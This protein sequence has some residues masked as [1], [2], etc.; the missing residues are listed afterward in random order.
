MSFYVLT[1]GFR[2]AIV[3]Q[4]FVVYGDCKYHYL[5]PLGLLLEFYS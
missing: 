3:R 4:A 5:K 1:I 2:A